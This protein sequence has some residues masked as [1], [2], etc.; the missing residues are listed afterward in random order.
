MI[1]RPGFPTMSPTKSILITSLAF[2]D[3]TVAAAGHVFLN[4]KSQTDAVPVIP[5]AGKSEI[6]LYYFLR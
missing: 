1:L 2:H 3:R 5:M 6:I 4:G